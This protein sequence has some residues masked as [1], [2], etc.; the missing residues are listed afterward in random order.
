MHSDMQDSSANMLMLKPAKRP[1]K[2]PSG[3]CR[4]QYLIICFVI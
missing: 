1:L 2:E 3:S 4:F